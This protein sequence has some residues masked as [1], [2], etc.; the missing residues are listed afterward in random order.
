MERLALHGLVEEQQVA[1]LSR[2]DVARNRV[3]IVTEERGAVG[4]LHESALRKIPRSN[5]AG[6]GA[7][8]RPPERPVRIMIF[9]DVPKARIVRKPGVLT[10]R[11]RVGH[12]RVPVGEADQ[13]RAV[14]NLRPCPRRRRVILRFRQEGEPAGEVLTVLGTVKAS[15]VREAIAQAVA[16]GG[17]G[18]S[19]TGAGQG[20]RAHAGAR[21]P[22]AF[23][24]HGPVA[25]NQAGAG[26]QQGQQSGSCEHT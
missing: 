9:R 22:R 12:Q 5:G 26:R 3:G 6:P 20:I 1:G 21:P 8:E 23:R 18:R 16:P 14:L 11:G 25:K 2:A 13:R 4:K 7:E 10:P 24:K 17:A 15:A 19:R